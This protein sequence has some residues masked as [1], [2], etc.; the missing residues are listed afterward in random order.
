MPF[1]SNLFL[2]QWG[3]HCIATG[4]IKY[5]SSAIPVWIEVCPALLKWRHICFGLEG[6]GL[7]GVGVSLRC[8]F[9]SA[10]SRASNAELSAVWI[11]VATVALLLVSVGLAVV[12]FVE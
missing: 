10:A 4:W 6:V 5:F 7:A 8:V 9:L 11:M 2:A 1:S 12:S 3:L